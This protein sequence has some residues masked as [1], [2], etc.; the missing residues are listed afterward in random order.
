MKRT[1]RIA[2]VGLMLTGSIHAADEIPFPAALKDA[3]VRVSSLVDPHREGLIVGNGDLYGIVWERDGILTMRVTKND[4]WDARV[5]TSEDGPL[6]RVDVA[7]GKVTGPTG[8]PPSYGKPYPHPR[9]AAVLRLGAAGGEAGVLWT[10]IRRATQ[11]G[12]AAAEDAAGAI[13]HVAGAQAASTGYSATLTVPVDASTC[14]LRLRGSPNVSYYVNVYDNAGKAVLASGW[15]RSPSEMTDVDLAFPSSLVARIEVYAMT[16][17][18]KRA[19]NRIEGLSLSGTKGDKPIDLSRPEGD[20]RATLDLRRAVVTVRQPEQPD[21]T[22]RVLSDRNMVL[23]RGPH[24]LTLEPISAPTLP[25]AKTGDTGGVAW[26]HMVMPGDL[27][28]E[29][30]AYALAVAAKDDLKAVS[31]V[32]SFDRGT[33]DVLERAI[34]LADDTIR[35]EETKLVA[36]HEQAWEEYWSR[37]GVQ[38]ADK[39]LQ[40]WWY[41]ILYFANTVCKPGAAPVGIMPPLAT[42]ATPWHA[43]YHHNYNTWQAFWPLPACNQPELADP[44][45]SYV[46]DMLPRFKYLAEVTYGIDGVFFPISSFL[47]EPDPAVC[48]GKNKRQM[49]MNPWG[50]TIGLVGMTIQSMWHKHL[51]EPDPAYLEEKIYP[52]LREGARFYVSFMKQ[53]RKD[54][55]GKVL[56]GPSY[57]PEHGP[58]GI[59]N[60]PFDIAYVHYTFD[61]FIQAAGELERD[62]ELVDQC[63]KYKALLSDYPTTVHN[64]EEI[65]VDWEGGGHIS[66]HNITVPAAPVFPGDQVTWF[67]PEPTKELFRRTI[68]ATGFNGN[69]SHVMFNI[70]KA[71]LSMPDAVTDAKKWFVSRELPNGLFV[72]KGHAHGTYMGEMIGIA[73]LVNEFLMQSV[74]Q[75]IRVFPCWP[76]NRDAEFTRLRAHGGFLVS[77]AQKN[78]SV[79]RVDVTSTVGGTLRL[80]S[81]WSAIAVQRAADVPVALTPDARGV[82]AVETR[83]DEEL[84]F[85]PQ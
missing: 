46:N 3:G 43:D 60:C 32:T 66:V 57:N 5:D 52:T 13:M 22:I 23:I 50:L 73:G 53:C 47:H 19:E 63:R 20:A 75:A 15:K 61:A 71:R 62:A 7:T 78:G 30:M 48:K 2:L 25:P 56:L 54:T 6:P 42:D 76:E 58:M 68:R 12:F 1:T 82:V 17:D 26:L 83:A 49:S 11:H 74:G 80:L 27:D 14:R 67:S 10:C 51:C 31:L 69:N 70:A 29:G 40:R 44:W 24:P 18:G 81:P 79:T 84:V 16:S 59:N 77:A 21:T 64:G 39:E 41:R 38:L 33:G 9:C 36:A 35:Q 65:V 34:A 8:A 85:L 72:W 45:I 55:M 37:S 4:I 28:Y